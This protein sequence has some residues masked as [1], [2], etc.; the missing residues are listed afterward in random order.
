M[1]P[2]PI[3]RPRKAAANLPKHIDP[4]RIPKGIYWDAA[5][6]RWVTRERLPDGRN[7]TRRVAGAEAQLSDLHRIAEE[8]RGTDTTS[9]AGI[10]A[11]FEASPQW[12]ELSSSTRKDYTY[13]RQVL[14]TWPTRTRGQSIGQLRA[15]GITRPLVQRL[16]DAIAATGPSKAAH[17]RRYLSR[18]WEWSANRGHVTGINPATGID[19]PKERQQRRLPDPATMAALI[20]LAHKRGQIPQNSEGSGP[21]YLWAVA[22]LAYLCRLRGIE[23]ITLTEDAA[24]DAGLRTNRRKGSRDN[25]VRWTP[26]LRAAW[27]ALIDQRDAT[28]ARKRTPVPIRPEQRPVVVSRSGQ[29]LRKSTL[30][31]AWQRLI[32]AAIN[33]GVITPDQRFALHDL[34][35]RGITDTPGTRADKQDASGHR[36]QG[37]LD[38]YDHSLP[39]VSPSSE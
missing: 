3:G 14:C 2:P 37:M 8:R 21:P 23:V 18:I 20:Q 15:Q 28:W 17:V 36:D 13:C 38:V 25:I 19:M 30:D 34:K 32:T 7:S 16:V 26:R 4:D 35:R 22:E 31:T 29:P 24:G 1:S 39:V 11:L 6:R 5:G 10:C 27:Q 12:R 9:L 33:D